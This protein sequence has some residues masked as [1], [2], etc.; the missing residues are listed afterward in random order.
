[1]DLLGKLVQGGCAADGTVAA[2]NPLSQALDGVLRV[3]PMGRPATQAPGPMPQGQY[4][5]HDLHQAMQEAQH[6]QDQPFHP[7]QMHPDPRMMNMPPPPQVDMNHAWQQQYISR[8]NMQRQMDH[9]FQS[10][11][12]APA[13]M[14]D[15]QRRMPLQENRSFVPMQ[16]YPPPYMQSMYHPPGMHMMQPPPM[17]TQ[18]P[19][20]Y[21]QRQVESS[22]VQ[23]VEPASSSDT[24]RIS[25]E[26]ADTMR[27]SSD[28]R[29]QN[30]E[31]L[32]FMD[33]VG[34][35]KAELN[36]AE[37]TVI[38]HT[39]EED[40]LADLLEKDLNLGAGLDT[41]AL[42]EIWEKAMQ[43]GQLVDPFQDTWNQESTTV[44]LS[45][46]FA[47][48]NPYMADT[49]SFE[50]GCSLFREGNLKQAILAFEAALQETPD[51]S[52]AWRMLGEC[53]AENDQD[54]LAIVCLNR[55]VEEDP[56]N[57]DALLALGVSNVN[58]LKSHGALK[59]LQ[60]WV[61]HNPKFHGLQV[62]L[63]DAYG[64]GSL[65]DEV[66]QL[67]LQAQAYD[68]QDSDVQVVLGVLYN[69]SKDYDAAVR[70][71]RSAA[72]ARPDEYSLWNKLGATLANSSR[73]NEAIPTYHRA[74]EIK[75]KYARGWL[76][77]GI[78]HANLGQYEDA[79][80]CYLQALQQNDQ[81]DHIWSYLR[82]A[83]T[84]MERF[85]LVKLTDMKDIAAFRNEFRLVDL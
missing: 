58:E 65:M 27:Q 5:E 84:C 1:M 76:N 37:N 67:M 44:D 8:D 69:V 36:D 38:H 52:E 41:K 31:F 25:R 16:Q 30:S 63:D 47:S 72:S 34:S 9:A 79:A 83:F 35:G 68:P 4:M 64:D 24:Q 19:M 59:T 46:D 13:P 74:L 53:H 28:E 75:P 20:V 77:L 33:K 40:H 26:V 39:S 17:L 42:E 43:E 7:L 82:I 22:V 29:F 70:C 11:V 49:N 50:L 71:F 45:Y 23:Q 32:K 57:L 55:A 21:E 73:S 3:G 10:A 12:A 78:S 60:A 6:M 54:K 56:Y 66:M 80:H 85:D 14:H 61:Q 81:A 2:R 15:V 62:Q 51:H 48:E 18:Q